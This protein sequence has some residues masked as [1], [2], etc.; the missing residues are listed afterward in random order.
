MK[1]AVAGILIGGGGIAAATPGK[2]VEL[3][4]GTI[5]RVRLDQPPVDSVADENRDRRSQKCRMNP[6]VFS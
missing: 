2:D 3:T 5:L 1:G 6:D 4:P